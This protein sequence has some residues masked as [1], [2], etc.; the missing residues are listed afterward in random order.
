M[1]KN[2]KSYKYFVKVLDK[3]LKFGWTVLLPNKNANTLKNLFESI[4]KSSRRSP[5]WN[6]SDNGKHFVKRILIVFL[7]E[8]K[9]KQ[10]IL[11]IQRKLDSPKSLKK[12]WK[13]FSKNLFL[14]GH[15]KSDRWN[16][17]KN[18]AKIIR[19]VSNYT[20]TNGCILEKK[21]KIFLT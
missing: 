12:S 11:I 9:R 5:N 21:R 16:G 4:L 13:I 8:I 3:F 17:H 20:N 19:K 18:E 14:E 1:P 10:I 2:N 15:L 6:E 7:N